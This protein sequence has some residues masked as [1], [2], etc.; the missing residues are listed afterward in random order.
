MPLPLT[1]EQPV[2]RQ[3]PKPIPTPGPVPIDRGNIKVALR[4]A[5]PLPVDVA[6]K[7]RTLYIKLIKRPMESA[8]CLSI[9]VFALPLLFC[10]C[11][12]IGIEQRSFRKLIY[13][14]DRLGRN[15]RKFRIHKLRTMKL[16]AEADGPAFSSGASDLRITTVGRF[17]RRYRIDELPQLWNVIRGDMALIGPRP[18]RPEFCARIESCLPEFAQR[19]MVRPGITGWAQVNHG[20]VGANLRGHADKLRFDLEYIESLTLGRDLRILARTVTSV[21]AGQGQ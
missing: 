19:L 5:P 21:L 12:A 14:Q 8:V 16:D 20:Y 4:L 17:L 6:P 13:S 7:L 11:I 2:I 3:L 1:R 15:R 18:E 10:S 9:G